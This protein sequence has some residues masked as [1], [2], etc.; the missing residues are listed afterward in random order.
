MPKMELEMM[1]DAS[2]IQAL[3]DEIVSLVSAKFKEEIPLEI[4]K[5]LLE[6]IEDIKLVPAFREEGLFYFRVVPGSKL[7]DFLDS[8]RRVQ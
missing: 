1:L 3:T 7:T 5:K 8:L 6:A 4:Q 2:S